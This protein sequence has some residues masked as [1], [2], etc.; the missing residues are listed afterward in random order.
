MVMRVMKSKILT[1]SHYEIASPLLSRGLPQI[2]S[3]LPQKSTLMGNWGSEDSWG[4]PLGIR[5]RPLEIRGLAISLHRK[6]Q[7]DPL[8]KWRTSL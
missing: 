5:G 1:S 4:R 8:Q 7:E 2:P 6:M 3:G